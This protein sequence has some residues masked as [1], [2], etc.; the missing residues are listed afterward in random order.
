MHSVLPRKMNMWRI[1]SAAASMMMVALC[2]C[3][4]MHELCSENVVIV[5]IA[6]L[7]KL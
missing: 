7:S 1:S 2:A 3:V 5:A 6:K 4:G